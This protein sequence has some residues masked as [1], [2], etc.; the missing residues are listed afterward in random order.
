VKG[1]IPWEGKDFTKVCEVFQ[2]DD[3]L[4]NPSQHI[5]FLETIATYGF[6]WLDEIPP[7]P[8]EDRGREGEVDVEMMK[9]VK[10]VVGRAWP[11]PSRGKDHWALYSHKDPTV[12]A[13]ANQDYD[14]TK[15]LALHT[16]QCTY[17]NGNYLMWFFQPFGVTVPHLVDGL[18][19]VYDFAKT[20]PEYFK[21]LAETPVAHASFHTLY[22]VDGRVTDRGAD[23]DLTPLEVDLFVNEPTIGLWMDAESALEEI[24]K[25]NPSG[26]P[27]L[28]KLRFRE[29]KRAFL[30]PEVVAGQPGLMK[31]FMDAYESFEKLL[32]DNRFACPDTVI[33]PEGR[34]LVFNNQRLVHTR[35]RKVMKA[36]TTVGCCN[37]K[38]R[39]NQAYRLARM[40]R[41]AA[42]LGLG[43]EWTSRLLEPSLEKLYQL[44]LEAE[45][46][47]ER[48]AS[49]RDGPG[50]LKAVCVGGEGTFES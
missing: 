5:R 48:G 37:T 45:K 46:E 15:P 17:E 7:P 35:P 11:H 2:V 33:Y 40:R 47:N 22:S 36:R 43:S 6:A 34:A 20:Q 10:R 16:D 39:A 49:Q 14:T 27:I 31:E 4:E 1:Q 3:I 25:G 41:T 38:E 44:G 50:V 42:A 8:A 29:H 26:V 12:S 28:R 32:N 13:V 23:R 24:R 9:V 18:A 30:P 21:I 19:V